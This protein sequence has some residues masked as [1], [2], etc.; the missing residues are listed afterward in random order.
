MIEEEEEQ[1]EPI[2]YEV[3]SQTD[4]PPQSPLMANLLLAAH[5]TQLSKYSMLL[6]LVGL[7][8]VTVL[9]TNASQVALMAMSFFSP[10]SSCLP[11]ATD[12]GY[13]AGG[14]HNPT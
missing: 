12:P 5:P 11:A 10:G 1:L 3:S 4:M 6:L 8:T 2:K 14:L 13:Q 9:M 7:T